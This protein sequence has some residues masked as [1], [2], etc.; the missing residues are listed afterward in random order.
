MACL[1]SAAR[2]A[3][4]SDPDAKR[5]H[6]AFGTGFRKE[7]PLREGR[8]DAGKILEPFRRDVGIH[9]HDGQLGAEDQRQFE[10][11]DECHLTVLRKIRGV[12]DP[13]DREGIARRVHVRIE[14]R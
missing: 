12:K 5:G 7:S 4:F 8:T 13:M 9:M 6:I 1:A 10:R 14:L 2:G 11:V 3:N